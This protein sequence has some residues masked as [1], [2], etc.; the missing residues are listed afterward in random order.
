MEVLVWLSHEMRKRSPGPH[1]ML[2]Y[3]LPLFAPG[4][5]K[6]CAR[7]QVNRAKHRE[8]TTQHWMGSG[9]ASDHVK[10]IYIKYQNI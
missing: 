8:L 2:H 7:P 6:F 9:G 10:K 3:K 4:A 1:P 5:E